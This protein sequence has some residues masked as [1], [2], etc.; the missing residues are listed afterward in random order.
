MSHTFNA[1]G[2]V[3]ITFNDEGAVYGPNGELEL[4]RDLNTNDCFTLSVFATCKNNCPG[5][6]L[7]IREG[8]I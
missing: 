5:G 6:E 8:I 3:E 7:F 4:T 2:H 1:T